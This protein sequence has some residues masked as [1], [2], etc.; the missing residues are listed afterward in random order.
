MKL[1]GADAIAE[2]MGAGRD[3][4][5]KWRDEGA[6]LSMEKRGRTWVLCAD[7]DGLRAWLESRVDEA[8]YVGPEIAKRLYPDQPERALLAAVFMTYADMAKRFRPASGGS[9]HVPLQRT[10]TA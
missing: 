9:A 4:V 6:P 8:E 10:R 5:A 7:E 2:C 1:L 3:D